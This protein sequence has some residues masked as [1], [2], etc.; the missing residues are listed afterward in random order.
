ML[1]I[2]CQI[3]LIAHVFLVDKIKSYDT[4]WD[5]SRNIISTR[6]TLNVKVNGFLSGNVSRDLSIVSRRSRDFDDDSFEKFT[7]RCSCSWISLIAAS[8]QLCTCEYISDKRLRDAQRLDDEESAKWRKRD[9]KIG[10]GSPKAVAFM[11][12]IY[13]ERHFSLYDIVFH[14]ARRSGS[15]L[16]KYRAVRLQIGDLEITWSLTAIAQMLVRWGNAGPQVYKNT[17]REI[18]S[19]PLFGFFHPSSSP[20][21]PWATLVRY[22]H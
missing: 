6:V 20:P 21:L 10:D 22:H 1:A 16:L 15:S 12:D 13:R 7:E 2:Y 18:R 9:G 8:P 19:R 11:L 4:T 3:I 17:L 14:A 5:L